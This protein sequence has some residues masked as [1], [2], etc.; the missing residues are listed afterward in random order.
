MDSKEFLKARKLL[1]K[2]Q[3]HLSELLGISIKAVHSYEQGWRK[4]PSHV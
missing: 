4:V 3:K 1:N 2:T